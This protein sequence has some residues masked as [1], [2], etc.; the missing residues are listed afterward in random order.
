MVEPAVYETEEAEKR[1][2]PPDPRQRGRKQVF[3]AALVAL[4]AFGFAVF[5]PHRPNSAATGLTEAKLQ[6]SWVLQSI[7]KTATGPQS[8][9]PIL[10]QQVTFAHGVV[11]GTTRL[12][13]NTPD[14]TTQMPFPDKSVQ[15][16]SSDDDGQTLLI[17]W[18]G[19]YELKGPHR[20]WLKIG[21][22][23]YP[24]D[25]QIDPKTHAL[26]CSH[27]LILTYPNATRYVPVKP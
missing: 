26:I 17:R 1:I 21:K 16:V 18:Q 12:L 27:D 15:Q 19:T 22:A 20:L 14:G 11:T 10:D 5:V 25:A 9:C 23:S 2:A 24:I 4:I 13:A 3:A 7:G 8:G 6:G